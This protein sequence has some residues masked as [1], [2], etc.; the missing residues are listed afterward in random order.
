[1]YDKMKVIHFPNT[2]LDTSSLKSGTVQEQF[3]FFF[4]TFDSLCLFERKIF[5]QRCQDN[6]LPPSCW[7]ETIS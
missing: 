2:Y 6:I 1:M 7:I 4:F 3:F 5:W